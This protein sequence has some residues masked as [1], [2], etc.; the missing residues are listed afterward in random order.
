VLK[1]T[2]KHTQAR[3]RERSEGV[4]GIVDTDTPRMTDQMLVSELDSIV[5]CC[6]SNVK[7]YRPTILVEMAA[8]TIDKMELTTVTQRVF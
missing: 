6:Q 4:R 3:N 5:Y 7:L 1:T 2:E 8:I